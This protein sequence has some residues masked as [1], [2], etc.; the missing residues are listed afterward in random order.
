[1]IHVYYLCRS[2]CDHRCIFKL[3]EMEIV[4]EN[5][6]LSIREVKA[7]VLTAKENTYPKGSEISKTALY[8]PETKDRFFQCQ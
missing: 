2:C 5:F 8:S 3:T 7:N 4:L 1:M 6:Q